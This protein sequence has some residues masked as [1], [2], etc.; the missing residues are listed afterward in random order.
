MLIHSLQQDE[1]WIGTLRRQELQVVA[2]ISLAATAD[3]QR[4][5]LLIMSGYDC[6]AFGRA[7]VGAHRA[8]G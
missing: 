4:R 5:L 8:V 3:A 1:E 2:N 6:G 7:F